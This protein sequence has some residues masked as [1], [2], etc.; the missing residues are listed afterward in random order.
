MLMRKRSELLVLVALAVGAVALVGAAGASASVK[1]GN[2]VKNG[3]A[4]VG[5]AGADGTQTVTPPR[6]TTTGPFTE[7]LYGTDGF[8]DLTVSA[9]IHGGT[10]F[11][12]GGYTTTVTRAKQSRRVPLRWLRFVKRHRVRATLS[13]ALGGYAGQADYATVVARFLDR[14][15]H[16][17]K[18]LKV[19]PVTVADRNSVTSLLTRGASARVPARTRKITFVITANYFDGVYND[20][21]VDNVRLILKR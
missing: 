3:K 15:G 18:T 19:G 10:A 11:F 21:Y 1:S 16:R 2:L 9:A 20:G 5:A 8:P 12:A 17:L 6:W 4:E 7:V 14:R 13:A